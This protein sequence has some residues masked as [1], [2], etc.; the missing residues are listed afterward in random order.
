MIKPS[1]S[2]PERFSH[3]CMPLSNYIVV[4]CGIDDKITFR[5]TVYT[6]NTITKKWKKRK[7]NGNI[8][9]HTGISLNLNPFTN[10]I[11]L[12]GGRDDT[13]KGTNQLLSLSFGKKSNKQ[14]DEIQ[15]EKENYGLSPIPN[16]FPVKK[17][18]S[19]MILSKITNPIHTLTRKRP[20]SLLSN[21]TPISQI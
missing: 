13:F 10:E 19:L 9:S 12:F 11:L 15:T 1:G 6:Y 17:R 14:S 7:I 20:M 2:I 4:A 18:N 3:A 16:K 5:N 8:S 21:I